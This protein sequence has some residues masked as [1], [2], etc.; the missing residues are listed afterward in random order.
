MMPVGF[1]PPE[2]P[3]KAFDCH[4]SAMTLAMSSRTMASIAGF[5]RS[6]LIRDMI[7]SIASVLKDA[8][9]CSSV[10]SLGVIAVTPSE[11]SQ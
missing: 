2:A 8:E 9:N 1:A 7:M 4:S 6:T 5:V 10:M 3:L 11:A